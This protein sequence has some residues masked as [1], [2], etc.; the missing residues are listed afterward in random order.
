MELTHNRLH[1]W[2]QLIRAEFDEIPDLQ[3]TQAQVEELW[4]L[5]STVAES[6]LS[7]LVAAGF[8]NRTRQGMYLWRD[9]DGREYDAARMRKR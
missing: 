1:D 2:L 4:Q 9:V 3:L 7:A 8:V 6:L 5:D